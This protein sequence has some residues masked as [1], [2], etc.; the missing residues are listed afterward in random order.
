MYQFHRD[1]LIQKKLFYF[2]II[3]SILIAISYL[4][5][6]TFY[7]ENI[8]YNTYADKLTTDRIDKLYSDGKKWQ[9]VG[10]LIIP[11]AL[12]LKVLYNSFWLTTGSL[13]HDNRGKFK[14]NYNVC[15]KAEYVFIIMGFVK[16]LWL[17]AFKKVNSL[18]DLGFVPGSIINLFKENEIPIWLTYP[19]QTLNI[20][21]VLFCI[22]GTSMYSIQFNVSKA[23]A[24]QLFCVPYLIGLFIWVLIVSFLTLQ[25]T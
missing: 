12:I 9:W 19:L 18:T 3:A 1:L 25:L 17:V 8:Y 11:V 22:V 20:W 14:N 24:A 5:Q 2:L 15:L 13:L 10:F 6:T 21:E 16:F 23:K 7:G 4:L